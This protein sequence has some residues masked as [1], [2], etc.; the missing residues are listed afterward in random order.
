M[1]KENKKEIR[2]KIYK[3]IERFIPKDAKINR[4]GLQEELFNLF[5]QEWREK[6]EKELKN[7]Y[8]IY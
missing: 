6:I 4:F 1:K 3:L 2:N 7:Y 8:K 5:H